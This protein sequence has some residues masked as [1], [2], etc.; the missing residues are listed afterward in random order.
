LASQ[1]LV[2][3]SVIATL[4]VDNAR[5]VAP[6]DIWRSVLYLRVHSTEPLVRMPPL[7]RNLVDT[8]A[9]KVLVNWIN[10][11]PGT[12]AQPPPAIQPNGGAFNSSALVTLS[13]DDPG[14]T[15]RYTLDGTL[16]NS[17]STIYTDP[18][19]M[20]ASATV[21]ASAFKTG[22]TTS[23]ASAAFFA[24]NRPPTVQWIDPLD[25]AVFAAPTDI[26]IRVNAVDS[27]GV[28][29]AVEFF[30]G[31]NSLGQSSSAPFTFIWTNV[32]S[33]HYLLTATATDDGGATGAS[34]VVR[35]TVTP[36][37][38]D[39][40]LQ[41][42]QISI[43]WPNSSATYVLEKAVDLTPPVT[44]TPVNR[45]QSISGGKVVVLIDTAAV[46][47]EFYRLRPQSP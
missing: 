40:G 20:N 11:L 16:P 29:S 27:D 4:G 22:Y 10:S 42:S 21:K 28:V 23:A 1:N 19:T 26:V 14:A 5:V 7:A 43:S 31:T 32:L 9:V 36:P 35:I 45:G 25:G 39:V 18:F 34:A 41:G 15:L 6:D 17:S 33:G 2:N 30:D 8:N 47:Q 37:S 38:L 44:W 46:S 12:P 3:G 24:V 13:D